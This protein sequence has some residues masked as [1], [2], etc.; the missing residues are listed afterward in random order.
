MTRCRRRRSSSGRSSSV[1][2]CS[3]RESG[4]HSLLRPFA[5]AK[6]H[7]KS[8]R[9]QWK[10]PPSYAK[11]LLFTMDSCTQKNGTNGFFSYP[12]RPKPRQNHHQNF[13]PS[14]F[15]GPQKTFKI[16]LFS[17]SFFDRFGSSKWTPKC[18]N[19]EPQRPPRRSW[20]QVAA[21]SLVRPS[22]SDFRAQ[23]AT[24]TL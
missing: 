13:R 9:P 20:S 17:V 21:G 12:H 6:S 7:L 15:Q 23:N 8:D 24:N 18:T 19:I 1:V 5:P 3:G 10:K 22:E 2:A 14:D 11:T 4:G 16:S